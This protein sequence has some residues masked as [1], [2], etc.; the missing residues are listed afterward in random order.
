M[1]D[2]F[3]HPINAAIF[4]ASGGIGA[5][6]IDELVKAD[7]VQ[8]VYGFSRSESIR[9]DLKY[10]HHTLDVTNEEAIRDTA[11]LIRNEAQR[12]NLIIIATGLLHRDADSENGEIQ[13]E[14]SMRSLDAK[15]MQDIF[16]VN[17]IAPAMIM[18]YFLPLIPRDELSV[19]AA[20]SARVG[21]ISDNRMGGWYSYR[22]SKAA[23]NMLI[24]S[25]AIETE[26]KYKKSCIVGLHPGTVDTKLSKPFQGNVET[27]KLFTAQQ[28]SQYL[29]DVIST[30]NEKASGK[31]FDWKGD[32]I[33]P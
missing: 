24:K 6:F 18:K 11:E 27:G 30:L 22:S 31:C 12:L 32:E 29:L 4:G 33:L 7:H 21:S 14:K 13:P 26:R 5:A 2:N 20:L 8:H 25:F 3:Q 17:T 28:S 16:A 15:S 10:S 23:L 9:R 19:C 1:L